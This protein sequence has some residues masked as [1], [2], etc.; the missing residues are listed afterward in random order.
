MGSL[1]IDLNIKF[2]NRF[3]TIYDSEIFLMR[4]SFKYWEKRPLNLSYSRSFIKL[5][6]AITMDHLTD[7]AITATFP[8][9]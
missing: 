3:T 5:K 1:K 8:K 7:G 2:N 6:L 9:S 4:N